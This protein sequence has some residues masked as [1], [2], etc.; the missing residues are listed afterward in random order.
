MLLRKRH[1]Q[2][3]EVHIK[4][5]NAYH[6]KTGTIKKEKY[7]Y[8]IHESEDEDIKSLEY[9]ELKLIDGTLKYSFEA[10]PVLFML[11][12]HDK[13]LL[14]FLMTYCIQDDCTLKWN[15]IVG[16]Q[17]ADMYATVK[18]ERPDYN[19]IRQS[20]P[21]LVKNNIIQ[22]KEPE[23]Y[24]LNPMLYFGTS[25]YIKNNLIKA[26]SNLAANSGKTIIDSLFVEEKQQ[27]QN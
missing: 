3:Q 12:G 25:R 14:L 8:K 18:G 21:T 7:V 4:I 16:E 20:I 10:L 22:L 24:M 5:C 23:K 17:Y 9:K 26:H 1:R 13:N 15:R 11:N 19:V 2:F 6:I 27:L